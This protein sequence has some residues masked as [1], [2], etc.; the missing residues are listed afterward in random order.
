MSVAG[1]NWRDRRQDR[2]RKKRKSLTQKSRSSA[3]RTAGGSRRYQDA[4]SLR[5]RAEGA[6]RHPLS[7]L[8]GREN[9][10]FDPCDAFRQRMPRIGRLPEICHHWTKF[11]RLSEDNQSEDDQSEDNQ[12]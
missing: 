2:N 8:I 3:K 10:G 5:A 6:C 4:I 1:A 12:L 9:L 7:T 11:Q